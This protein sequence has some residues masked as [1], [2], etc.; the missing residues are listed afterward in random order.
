MSPWCEWILWVPHDGVVY[1]LCKHWKVNGKEITTRLGKVKQ[2][3][4]T[5]STCLKPRLPKTT[6]R[7][8]FM[9]LKMKLSG[10]DGTA[11][12]LNLH[13]FLS[14]RIAYQKAARALG[15][16]ILGPQ[17]SRHLES[18]Q[19]DML[20]SSAVWSSD[21]HELAGPR[22]SGNVLVNRDIWVAVAEWV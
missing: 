13:W 14:N 22:A 8:L 20:P 10:N 17:L 7:V 9:W 18:Q 15:H 19:G 21:V 16:D 3:T 1:Q 12:S 6:C 4:L 11:L 2:S 5:T